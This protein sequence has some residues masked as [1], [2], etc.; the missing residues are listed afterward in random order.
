MLPIDRTSIEVNIHAAIG[1]QAGN[2]VAINAVDGGERTT[3]K[4]FVTA[5]KGEPIDI[6]IDR[7]R[8]EV[9][10]HGAIGIQAGNAVVISAGDAERTTDYWFASAV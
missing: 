2:A 4:G 1:I 6:S 9:V 8:I 5:V 10:I 3:D 7:N